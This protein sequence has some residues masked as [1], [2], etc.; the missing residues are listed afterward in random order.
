MYRAHPYS[1]ALQAVAGERTS[2]ETTGAA[3]AAHPDIDKVAFT[4]SAETGKVIVK[5]GQLA[6]DA[7]VPFG[8]YKHSGL[9]VR[10]WLEGN[11]GLLTKQVCVADLA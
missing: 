1:E 2:G 10:I 3:M 7:S 8:G 9:G 11:R 6:S 5:A 4:G